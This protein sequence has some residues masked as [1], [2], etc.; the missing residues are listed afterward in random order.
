M[1]L[2]PLKGIIGALMFLV[3]MIVFVVVWTPLVSILP[4][5]LCAETMAMTTEIWGIILLIPAIVVFT[6]L[7]VIVSAVFE[8]TQSRF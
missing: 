6:G 2:N 1:Y 3:G 7:I 5:F 8:P 4:A